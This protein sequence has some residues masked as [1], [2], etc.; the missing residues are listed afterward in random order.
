MRRLAALAV[1][2]VLAAVGG[3]GSSAAVSAHATTFT[4]Y[5][6]D[7]CSAPSFATL[8]RTWQSEQSCLTLAS[9]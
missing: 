1:I 7:A 8:D 5:G 2:A 6:F 3:S 4:G 9:K